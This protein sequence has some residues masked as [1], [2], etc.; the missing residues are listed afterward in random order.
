MHEPRHI[1]RAQQFSRAQMEGFF[2]DADQLR[3]D[4]ENPHKREEFSDYLIDRVLFNIFYEPSTRTRMSFSA[5]AEYL[6]MRVV[7]TENAAEFSSHTK[8]ETL[9]DTIR[10]FNEYQPAAIVLRHFDTGS[11]RRAADVSDVPIINAGD[12]KGEHPTQA[13]LDV[14][15]IQRELGQIDGLNIVIGGDLAHGRTAR[16]LAQILARF[17]QVHI[18]FVAPKQLRIDGEVTDYLTDHGVTYAETEDL[19]AALAEADVVYWTRIQKERF[20]DPKLF[21]KVRNRYVLNAETIAP[22]K[23]DAIIMHPLPRTVEIATDLDDDP[24]AAYFRQTGNGLFM[25]MALLD[26]VCRP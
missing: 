23:A 10:V 1:L 12:G 26:W 18:I 17:K 5:A 13:L 22:L 19:A 11:A 9:E 2:A 8:G 14:Y 4:L 3:A 7:S 20:T 25:R 6:G 21:D 16:S 24:R 15:T